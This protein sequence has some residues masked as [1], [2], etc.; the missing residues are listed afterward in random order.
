MQSGAGIHV[1]AL[2]RFCPHIARTVATVA[3]PSSTT[4]VATVATPVGAA[5]SSLATPAS[6]AGAQP[7]RG[8]TLRSGIT[9]DIA[10]LD[11]TV[12]GV[13][14]YETVWLV[15]DRLTA[16]DLNLQPQPMLAESWELSPDDK[17]VK[18]NLRKNVTYHSGREFTSDD[19]KWNFA[20]IADPKPAPAHSP[21]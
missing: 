17:Q 1:N 10:T 14:Q 12:T 16:Y 19:V 18:L 3:T 15:Y 6:T 20:R 8:G 5:T 4:T 21:T 11:G 2:G 7:K 13:N 9:G